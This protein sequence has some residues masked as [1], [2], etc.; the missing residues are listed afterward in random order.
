MFLKM[1]SLRKKAQ[2]AG[3]TKYFTGK[4]CPAGH[5]DYRFTK[6]GACAACNKIKVGEWRSKNNHQMVE[7]RKE[8][9]VRDTITAGEWRRNNP[10]RVNAAN[11]KWRQAHPDRVNAR[12]AKRNAAKLQR[13]PKWLTSVDLLEMESIYE[14]CSALRKCGLNYHVDH[15]IPLR[16]TIVS[17]LHVPSNL[18]VITGTENVR[19]GNSYGV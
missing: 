4:P 1:T 10:E 2:A 16:G 5:I 18:Q 8:N 12:I 14:Y 17:G 11:K 6:S 19:K 3:E 15:I 13:T 7:Y 9:R